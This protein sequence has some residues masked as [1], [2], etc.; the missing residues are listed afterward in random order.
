MLTGKGGSART[1]EGLVGAGGTVPP[2]AR[3]GPAYRP[4]VSLAT[5]QYAYSGV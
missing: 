1:G 2:H 3:A 5:I 4:D